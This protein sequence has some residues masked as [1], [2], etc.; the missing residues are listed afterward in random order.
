LTFVLLPAD[1]APSLRLLLGGR[2]RRR[3]ARRRLRGPVRRLRGPGCRRFL[4]CGSGL[5]LGFLGGGLRRLG[6]LLHGRL[7]VWPERLH[8]RGRAAGKGL[9]GDVDGLELLG[10]IAAALRGDGKH[11]THGEAARPC[12]LL[13]AAQR[14]EAVDGRLRHVDRVRRAEA[15]REDV[16]DAG[17]L[18]HGTDTAAGDDAGALAR[19]AQQ[20]A[21]RV[22]RP[23]DLVR[24]RRTML[25]DRE[26]VLLRVLD[27]LRDRERHFARL[28]V[29]DADAVDLVANDDERCEREAAAALDDL[30]D[31]VDL[32]DALLQLAR[33]LALASQ[34]L[35]L[36]AAQNSSPPSRAPSASAFT[37]PW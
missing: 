35:T 31:A 23:D 16:A 19:R 6:Q 24:D 10:R 17:E 18:E 4:G 30:G 20:H 1:A 12:D 36:D 25:R 14:A 28:A 32:D 15:L 7:R 5:G 2:R 33:L 34:N 26:E 37:R 21:R 11:L 29:A 8:A 27:G 3:A 9:G 13:G 22:V